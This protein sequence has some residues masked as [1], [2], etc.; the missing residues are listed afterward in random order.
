MGHEA[1]GPGAQENVCKTRGRPPTPP[2]HRTCACSFAHPF[3]RR[4]SIRNSPESPFTRSRPT[5][6][7][8]STCARHD[9]RWCIGTGGHPQRAIVGERGPMTL[10]RVTDGVAKDCRSERIA[11]VESALPAYPA[12]RCWPPP[13]P[14]D[15][16]SRPAS[17]AA[18]T[19]R[20]ARATSRSVGST[21]RA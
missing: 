16:A 2:I 6:S 15:R 7:S 19:A 10:E 9:L 21:V 11:V 12:S 17:R 14:S 13:A 8:R 20:L 3:R 4:R 1:R 5:C 18:L